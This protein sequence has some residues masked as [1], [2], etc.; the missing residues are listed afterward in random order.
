M[1]TWSSCLESHTAGGSAFLS[2]VLGV[3]LGVFLC[4]TDGGWVWGM[5]LRRKEGIN[6]VLSLRFLP[7]VTCVAP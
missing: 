4:D 6:K 3:S 2:R 7:F 1:G 5:G